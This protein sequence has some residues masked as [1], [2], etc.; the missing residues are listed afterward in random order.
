MVVQITPHPN[1]L[2][3]VIPKPQV[4][5][6]VA[7]TAALY[8][9]STTDSFPITTSSTPT[10]SS[11]ST[12]KFLNR[13]SL[14]SISHNST[15]SPLL[16]CSNDSVP[17]STFLPDSAN[18]NLPSNSSTAAASTPI[19]SL[20]SI[21]TPTVDV[22]NNSAVTSTVTPQIA[23]ITTHTPHPIVG[24]RLEKTLSV[25]NV[26]IK[27]LF[28]TGSPTSLISQSIV[29]RNHWPVY[30]VKPLKWQGAIPGSSSTSTH[31]VRCSLLLSSTSSPIIVSAYVTPDLHDHFIVGNPII[32]THPTLL[33]FAHPS[34]TSTTTTS[35]SST[36]VISAV[37][38]LRDDDSTII[39]LYGASI[40]NVY[41]ITQTPTTSSDSFTLLPS[42][43]QKDFASTVTNELPAHAGETSF[44]HEIT[45]KEGKKPPRL[46]PYRLTPKLE[47]ECKALIQDLLNKGFI[48]NS[49]SPVSSPVLLVKKKDSTYRLVI[50]YRELNKITIKDPYPLPR[51]D[52]LMAKIGD[53]SIF[54]TLDLHSG[55]HQIPL[56]PDSQPLTGFSTPFGHYEYKVMPFGLCNAPATF[57]RYMNQLLSDLPHVFVYLDDILIASKDK[58]SHYTHLRKVLQRLKD[59]GLVCKRKKCHFMQPSV[60]FLGYTIDSN[61]FS[62][63]KDK[64]KAIKEFP[65]PTTIKKCQSFMGLVNFYRSFIP[66]C[67]SIAKP[68]FN[69]ISNKADWGNDQIKAVNIL[70]EKLCTAPTL[71][72]FVSGA[73]YRLTT[74]ASFTALGSVLERLDNDNKLIG[75][76]GYFSKSINKTQQ[77]YPIGELELFAIIESLKHFRYY[78]H[79]HHFILRTDHSSLLSLRNKTEP[80]TRIARWL[81]TLAEY[82]FSL[83]HIPGKKNVVADA[84]SRSFETDSIQL[85][86][87]AELSTIDPSRWLEDWKSDPWSAAVLV[88]L[89]VI[90]ETKVSSSDFSLFQKY[91]KKFKNAKK[92]FERYNYSNDILKYE[93][94]ICVPNQRRQELLKIYH[95]SILQG[96]HFG[97]ATT[98]NKILPIYYWPN[99]T[100]DIRNFVKSCLQCQIMKN[101]KKQVNGQLSPLPIPSGRWL[102]ISC[103]FITGLP[104]TASPRN[105]DMIMVVTD[106]FSKR[107]HFIATK[108]TLGSVGLIKLWYRY[109]F[110]YHGF[111]R[112]IV[113]DRDIRFTSGWYDELTNRLGIKLCMSSSNHP[114]SDGQTESTNKTLI[115]L[116]RSYCNIDQDRWDEFLPHIEFV[117]NSTYQRS[118]KA[119]PFEIDIGYIPNEPLLATNNEL[120]AQNFS[121]VEY[122]KHL[123]ALTLRTQDLLKENQEIME[124]YANKSRKDTHFEIGEYVLLHRDAYFT[125][126]RYIKTQPIYI[127]PFQIVK[128]N[129]NT[130]E[131][132]LPS[133]FK[134]HRVINIEH[135]KK[136]I[137][138]PN[139]YPNKLP[140]THEERLKRVADIIAIVG[141]DVKDQIY[142]CKLKNVDP[143]LVCEYSLD[144]ISTLPTSRLNSLLQNL[145]QLEGTI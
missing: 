144:E 59:E 31:A 126:G 1:V 43:L 27:V 35:I 125:G 44:T 137:H 7:S 68:L 61:G 135:I 69:F 110:S 119:S 8:T 22:V 101:Y 34:S 88:R 127:G 143:Q 54:T 98:I 51:I 52:D 41:L 141:Y 71:V 40:E 19:S 107:S 17:A 53:C 109:I 140:S 3:R 42:S 100:S 106:R 80:S 9:T 128:I 93:N 63:Q 21:P 136:Y 58:E 72:P 45:L 114:Q 120:Y 20:P 85:F 62:V 37:D 82:D 23:I 76:I 129:G 64:V 103:D 132:D 48:V 47:T 36:P 90:S 12:F 66:N 133:S 89:G 142:Y 131:L 28:D 25:N 84:L 102:D 92:S 5:F 105:N 75:V 116:L 115:R 16:N 67:S 49:K 73:K 94:R 134:K 112:T 79:G 123:K 81:D 130:C 117:Y 46:L 60:E 24:P 14:R 26:P 104:V 77:N 108:K 6:P 50:D 10:T 78:L 65:M 138:D 13:P 39:D 38:Y 97:E 55:Y 95:D 111:P 122:T 124:S 113:S 18:Q 74:D 87:I 70:K 56:S 4:S 121:A 145:K 29:R 33:S 96:G 32:S 11:S 139:R 2:M 83:E 86:P 91:L 57:C 15:Q 118:I 30:P 99:M